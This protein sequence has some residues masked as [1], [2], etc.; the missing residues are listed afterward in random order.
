MDSFTIKG[1]SDFITVTLDNLFGFPE[2]TSHWGG[3]D[4]SAIAEI[5]SRS[6][7]CKANFYTSTGEL[8]NFYQDL[9]KCNQDLKGIAKYVSYEAHLE[10]T[11]EYDTTGHVTV[12]GMF[13]E[14]SLY[15]NELQFEFSSDQSHIKSTIDELNVLVDKYGNMEGI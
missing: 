11:L 9:K 4:A 15:A 1:G 12:K 6:F 10:L 2:E 13:S 3:Y 8:F 7:Y 5:K 14:H